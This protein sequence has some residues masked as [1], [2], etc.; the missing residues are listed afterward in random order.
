MR[1]PPGRICF[2]IA[3]N[4][5]AHTDQPGPQVEECVKQEHEPHRVSA[6]TT[7]SNPVILAIK[8]DWLKG[9]SQMV[10]DR[11]RDSWS[12]YLVTILFTQF[13][14]Q[15]AAVLQRMKDE[16]ERIY[17]TL[18]TRVH[19]KPR[20]ASSDE[21]PVFLGAFDLPVHKRDQTSAPLVLCNGG[22][23][24]HAVVLMPPTSRLRAPLDD[25]FE[26]H[27]ELYRGP[28]K[29]V[30]RIDVRPVV[31]GHDRVVDYVFKTVLK[32]RLAYDDGMLVLPR[33]RSELGRPVSA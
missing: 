5:P 10:T 6:D 9:Y 26:E 17:S 4:Q 18:V 32:G 19:R 24:F 13:F 21:L 16:V 12:P 7:A 1:S 14:G 28:R 11:V 20:N 8:P 15:K 25:H 29:S 22:L 23:H 3:N 27:G 2:S 30:L 31:D 33:A